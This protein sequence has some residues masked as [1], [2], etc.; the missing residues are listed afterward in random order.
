M[1]KE[2]IKQLALN[3]GFKLKEQHDGSMDLN[4]YVYEFADAI[5]K[6]IFTT[7]FNLN[8]QH[9]MRGSEG[10]KQIGGKQ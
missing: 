8:E 3:N 5:Q 6:S 10:N 2:Q 7:P 4:P 9:W 1:N